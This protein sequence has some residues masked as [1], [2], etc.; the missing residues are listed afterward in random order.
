M[1]IIQHFQLINYLEPEV[2][3]NCEVTLFLSSRLL[4]YKILK[5]WIYTCTCLLLC[6]Y[7]TITYNIT[8]M[9]WA[10][11]TVLPY[12]S[13]NNNC[14]GTYQHHE[15]IIIRTK[16]LKFCLCIVW[17]KNCHLSCGY[18]HAQADTDFT[19][20]NWRKII[21]KF[22]FKTATTNILN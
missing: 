21:I 15:H 3:V 19:V 12:H 18:V 7:N 11:H 16:A 10:T 13:P 14:T 2:T 5:R 8:Y 4:Q 1:M 20:Q 22:Q 17:R 9:P 6:L